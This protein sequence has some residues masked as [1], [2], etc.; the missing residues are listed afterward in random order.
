MKLTEALPELEKIAKDLKVDLTG[1]N[2]RLIIEI[3]FIKQRLIK[4]QS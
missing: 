3:W 4:L 1:F 2:L